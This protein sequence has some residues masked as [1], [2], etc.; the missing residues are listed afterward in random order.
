MC[1]VDLIGPSVTFT[2]LFAPRHQTALVCR[3]H[4]VSRLLAVTSRMSRH[5][6]A[7]PRHTPTPRHAGASP[8]RP[9]TR[10]G[11]GAP[12]GKSSPPPPPRLVRPTAHTACVT[13]SPISS[14]ARRHHTSRCMEPQIDLVRSYLVTPTGMVCWP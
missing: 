2:L 13:V 8:A 12:S 6:W 9:T 5:E 1:C 14:H 11:R 10:L 7:P 3:G 4:L